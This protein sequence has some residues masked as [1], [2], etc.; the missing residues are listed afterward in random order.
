MNNK[1]SLDIRELANKDIINTVDD[2]TNVSDHTIKMIIDLCKDDD[3]YT[4]IFVKLSSEIKLGIDTKT[5]KRIA[6]NMK[7][8]I[9]R[10]S[11][12]LSGKKIEFIQ[13]NDIAA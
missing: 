12:L 8:D 9:E 3:I 5:I 6:E 2:F 4:N 1:L 10:N 13:R 7:E 11:A